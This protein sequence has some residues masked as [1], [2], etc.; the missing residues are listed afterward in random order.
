MPR[1]PKKKLFRRGNT[2]KYNK[3]E[4]YTNTKSSIAGSN[5]SIQ[6]P[7]LRLVLVM[8]A[9]TCTAVFFPFIIKNFMSTVTNGGMLKY[10]PQ[11]TLPT[12]DLSKLIHIELPIIN[13][14]EFTIPAVKSPEIIIPKIAISVP[15]LSLP[16]IS[17]PDFSTPISTVL[18]T[19]SALI[20]SMEKVI[21]SAITNLNPIPVLIEAVSLIQQLNYIT[22][23]FFLWSFSEFMIIISY[24]DPRPGL[25]ILA[26]IAATSITILINVTAKFVFT[27]AKFINPLPTI[28]Y[29]SK[30]ELVIIYTIFQ[31]IMSFVNITGQG[32]YIITEAI[33]NIISTIFHTIVNII[34]SVYTSIA[35]FFNAVNKTITRNVDNTNR[36]INAFFDYIE[37][38][39]TFIV[40]M[41][42]QSVYE[43]VSGTKNLADT[44]HSIVQQYNNNRH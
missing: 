35:N 37:P 32:L 31:T 8:I 21:S 6:L 3:P 20:T 16:Q 36:Q 28:I 13:I 7:H 9:L 29:V 14:P 10:I 18:L 40:R 17:L 41:F 34:I 25:I 11:I 19:V 26:D 22:F 33:F 42:K 1:K 23:R 38:Y 24:L 5:Y 44:T 12:V 15:E 43:L 39:V 4:L 2:Q 27:T 30:I